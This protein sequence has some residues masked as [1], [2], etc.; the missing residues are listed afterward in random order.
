MTFPDG[1]VISQQPDDTT[2]WKDVTLN[3]TVTFS[4]SSISQSAIYW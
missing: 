3:G 2:F 4:E 1:K